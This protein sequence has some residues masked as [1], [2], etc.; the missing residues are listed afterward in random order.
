MLILMVV[1]TGIVTVG[2]IALAI[3]RSV[4]V[5]HEENV[6]IIDRAEQNLEKQF[7][8]NLRRVKK[9]ESVLK[10]VTAAWA[11]LALLTA[12]MWVYKGLYG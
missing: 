1:T 5:M 10:A 8:D 12:A 11:A 3:Y 4:L 9:V 7:S 2:L 6:V